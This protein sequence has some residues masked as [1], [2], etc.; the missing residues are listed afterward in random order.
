M[1]EW[2]AGV[3]VCGGR[4]FVL[5]VKV[6]GEV[7]SGVCFP[8]FNCSIRELVLG[9]QETRFHDTTNT[10]LSQELHPLLRKCTWHYYLIR[11]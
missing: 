10:K 7:T 2:V 9:F 5:R 6:V 8:F 4:S 1:S 11:I 3:W